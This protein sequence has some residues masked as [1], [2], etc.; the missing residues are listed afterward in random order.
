MR[1]LIL[2]LALLLSACASSLQGLKLRGEGAGGNS[3]EGTAFIIAPNR[4][5]T[6]AHVYAEGMA[7]QI[8]GTPVQWCFGLIGDGPA[9]HCDLAV[10]QADVGGVLCEI[11][12]AD[13][14]YP[15]EILTH[16]GTLTATAAGEDL[17]NVNPPI[18]HGDSGS[19]VVQDGKLVGVL[20]G[21]ASEE[22]GTS[23]KMVSGRMLHE[24]FR[25]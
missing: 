20:W 18:R 12:N 7:W 14:L 8:E 23:G 4:L 11:G 1:K 19:A 21:M 13:P 25:R 2:C 15:V 10:I 24:F 9:G 3:C 5:L 22:D 17:W 6:A 16:R